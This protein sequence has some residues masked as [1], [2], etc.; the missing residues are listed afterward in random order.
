MTGTVY[1]GVGHW[2]ASSPK[3]RTS[4]F[5]RR[6]GGDDDWRA[7]TKGLPEN[8]DRSARSS[9]IR[10][11]PR[12]SS[13][14]RT[15]GVYR[16]DDGG[17]GRGPRSRCRESCGRSGRSPSIRATPDTVF[18]GVEG[19]AIWRT[20]DGGAEWQLLDVPAPG[21]IPECPFA[22][23]VTRI[24]D[25]PQ[26]AR[27]CLCRAGSAGRGPQPRRRRQLGRRERRPAGARRGERAPARAGCSPAIR[28]R[29]DGRHPRDF[30]L[31]RNEPWARSISPTA[32]GC[33]RPR[34][35]ARAG[36]SSASA[37]SR[38]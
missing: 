27:P 17:D 37:G 11:M 8:P 7:L 20:R 25:R 34:T 28:M 3:V 30:G 38:R 2:Q 15:D 24:A 6:R 9:S 10:G 23:R 32:W 36:P 16:S 22:T 19:F 33:S 13:R 4:G 31:G 14:A 1:A 21:G 29:V 5:F 12:P 26:P 18:V 35:R